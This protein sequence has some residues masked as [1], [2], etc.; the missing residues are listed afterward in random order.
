MG[1]IPSDRHAG[2]DELAS[3]IPY[4]EPVLSA[5]LAHPASLSL[6]ALPLFLVSHLVHP[7]GG[8]ARAEPLPQPSI[9]DTDTT[10]G[11][12][13]NPV[14]IEAAVEDPAVEGSVIEGRAIEQALT[15]L[16]ALLQDRE[17]SENHL[18]ELRAEGAPS[19][20]E[21]YG[22]ARFRLRKRHAVDSLIARP[23][24][25]V[26]VFFEAQDRLSAELWKV[27]FARDG[28]DWRAERYEALLAAEL[29]FRFLL[30]KDEVYA[31]DRLTI[32]RPA[33]V[34]HMEEGLLMPGFSDGRIGRVVLVGSGRFTFTPPNGVERQQMNKYARTSDAVYTTRFDR[35]VLMLSP[36]GY[37][38]LV[39]GV[40]LSASRAAGI[41]PGRKN[42]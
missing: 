42:C 23:E 38:K 24:V 22:Q 11:A 27:H 7:G 30:R 1:P 39:D 21:R 3:C 37:E 26:G 31:F 35:L 4:K 16:Y 8:N 36:G 10:R 15:E 14:R 29:G 13:A 32:E 25:Q 5:I 6:I 20:A 9:A 28:E 19:L 34:F 18:E 12:A 33:G 2:N 17:I 40:V 41:S